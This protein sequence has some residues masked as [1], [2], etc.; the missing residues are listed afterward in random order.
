MDISWNAI[1]SGLAGVQVACPAQRQQQHSSA[2][3]GGLHQVDYWIP[4]ITLPCL[5]QIVAIAMATGS[6]ADMHTHPKHAA[7]VIDAG[8]PF[9]WR[10][11]A[12]QW[13]MSGVYCM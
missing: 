11:S 4:Q 1:A 9:S 3:I 8:D 2:L 13:Q 5:K 7:N 10:M 6:G 12:F